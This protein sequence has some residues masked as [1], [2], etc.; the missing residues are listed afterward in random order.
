MKITGYQL[1]LMIIGFLIGSSTIVSPVQDGRDAW[2]VFVIS[3]GGG[4]ALIF[5]YATIA[6][7]HPGKT[8]VEIL[9]VCFGKTVGTILALLYIGY[10][11]HLAALVCR[12]FGFFL[13]TTS[14]PRTPEI[15]IISLL[16]LVSIYTLKKGLQVLGRATEIFVPILLVF[17]LV[18]FVALINQ[19]D[20]GVFFPLLED[21]LRIILKD[22]FGLL[23]FPFGE[24]VVFLMIF[25]ALDNRKNVRQAALFAVGAGGFLL[26]MSMVRDLMVLGPELLKRVYFPP[27]ISAK[28]IPIISL[29]PL[30][31]TNLLIAGG[32]KITV[33][34]YAAT[35][36]ITQVFRLDNDKYLAIPV[37]ILTV[38]L[39]MWL[40]TS[41][42]EM[43]AWAAEVYPYY[44][45]PFQFL[46]PFTVL[47]LSFF[48]KYKKN[49]QYS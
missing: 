38:A 34:L 29:D 24:T 22:S 40:Y 18:L 27:T 28:L 25:S 23:T 9:K 17:L 13:T 11:I 21:G 12:N 35:A 8:L 2:L 10:F 42:F 37:G 30:I 19:F 43:V 31:G 7:L 5:V 46:I 44:A 15:Y 3:W 45:I 4:C 20:F 32:V 33:C 48:S 1:T 6:L 41:I 16:V 39:A 14:Y 36:G 49:K 47:G 26:F